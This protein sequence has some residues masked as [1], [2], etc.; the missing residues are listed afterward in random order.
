MI[1]KD[2]STFWNIEIFDGEITLKDRAAIL[3][4]KPIK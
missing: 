4:L 1:L 3:Q 2:I